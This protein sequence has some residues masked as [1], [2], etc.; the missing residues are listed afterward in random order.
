MIG[1]WFQVFEL[2]AEE[3]LG[4]LDAMAGVNAAAW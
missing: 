1:L 3:G 4:D 2:G